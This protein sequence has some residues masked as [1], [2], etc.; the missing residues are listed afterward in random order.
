MD[1]FVILKSG[2]QDWKTTVA[3][4]QGRNPIWR[5]ERMKL[6]LEGDEIPED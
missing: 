5:H 6:L 1:P 2:E 3:E 4:N